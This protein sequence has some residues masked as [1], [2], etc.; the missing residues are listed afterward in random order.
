MWSFK[1]MIADPKL[2]DNED[3]PEDVPDDNICTECG[4]EK[5]SC[6]TCQAEHEADLKEDD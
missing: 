1:S 3:E 4:R 2:P 5:D 6:W